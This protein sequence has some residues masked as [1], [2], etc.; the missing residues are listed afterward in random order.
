MCEKVGWSCI[1]KKFSKYLMNLSLYLSHS[2]IYKY[3]ERRLETRRLNVYWMNKDVIRS[4]NKLDSSTRCETTSLGWA[5]LSE[6]NSLMNQ[7]KYE[8]KRFHADFFYS[9]RLL[10]R[11]A[12][13]VG[14]K[15]RKKCRY[16]FREFFLNNPLF[17]LLLNQT[18]TWNK[19]NWNIRKKFGGNHAT[20]F[21]KIIAL[22]FKD[23]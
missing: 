12:A 16:T 1:F 7:V 5:A 2:P 20:S 10:C 6:E 3:I 21:N 8:I 4:N 18:L 9:C 13:I 23:I 19:W 17:N 11:A 15:R 14:L 22:F